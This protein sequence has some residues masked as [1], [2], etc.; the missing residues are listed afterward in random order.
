[1]QFALHRR[2]FE[3]RQSSHDDYSVLKQFIVRVNLTAYCFDTSHTRPIGEDGSERFLPGWMALRLQLDFA[4]RR[5]RREN[6][7]HAEETK[8]AKKADNF[9]CFVCCLCFAFSLLFT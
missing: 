3:I 6:E 5:L 8:D 1:P 4:N 9:A 7:K 2:H